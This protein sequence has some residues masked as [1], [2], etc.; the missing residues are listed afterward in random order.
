MWV[1]DPKDHE[2]EYQQCRCGGRVFFVSKEPVARK[3]H[4]KSASRKRFVAE[5]VQCNRRKRIGKAGVA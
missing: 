1:E 3:V 5:C 2:R 4:K